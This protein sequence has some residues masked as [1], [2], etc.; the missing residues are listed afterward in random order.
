MDNWKSIKGYEGLY[1]VNQNGEIY[2]LISQKVLKPFYRGSRPDNKY[3]VVDLH[4][5][6]KGKTISV[7]R[8]VA[9]A[10]I[11]N[12]NNFPCVNHKDGN[13]N[14]NHV[15]NLEWCT[16]LE[17]NSHAFRT[18]LKVIPSGS[19]SKLSK[20]SYDD[21]VAIK[22][23]LVLG[24]SEFGTRPL[25]TK[26]GVDHKVIMDIYHNRKYQDVKI[27]YTFFV[28]SDIHS[29]Y[30]QWM[31]ALVQAGFN[32]NKYSHKIILC[33]DLFDRMYESQKVY[34]FVNDMIAKDKLIYIKGNHESLIMD[35]IKR[36][37]ALG[38]DYS[39]G[40]FQSIIDLAPE[41][42]TFEEACTIAYGKLFDLIGNTVDYVE[43]R[44]HVLVHGWLPLICTDNH[45]Q[46]HRRNRSFQYNPDWRNASAEEWE[47]ARWT[48]GPDMALNG[49]NQTGK[50][51]VFGHWHTSYLWAKTEG[52]SEFGEDAKFDIYHGD[53]FISIDACTA[54]TKK[55][56]VLVIEDEFLD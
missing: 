8:I 19:R 36:G 21:V 7:H 6:K 25:A 29:A 22:K 56:N 35:C 49:F 3:Q 48:C 16:Y 52:R 55:V 31:D 5:D 26:Y 17:N 12:P 27:P 46:Y 33:G 34:C 40:T 11:P 41:A 1:Q 10:F 53:G 20:L 32:E 38:H 42:C 4:K 39:N 15:D 45:P 54:H 14:N 23:C 28:S 51:V 24:D 37:Y 13:K 18:G 30:A 47:Q 44:H 2:S 50:V 9:E 43:L